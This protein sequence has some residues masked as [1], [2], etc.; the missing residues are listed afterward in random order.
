MFWANC[1]PL[2]DLGQPRAVGAF[3]LRAGADEAAAGEVEHAVLLGGQPQ[4]VARLPERLDPRE[5]VGVHPHLGAV[6]GE[7]GRERPHQLLPPRIAVGAGQRVE[8]AQHPAQRLVGPLQ[9]RNGVVVGG[10]RLLPGDG[11][12]VGARLG[13]RGL[14]RL[15]KVLVRDLCEGR[16]RVG[17]G[18]LGQQRVGHGSL[19][20]PESR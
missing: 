9:R 10:R 11:G 1:V 15:G 8:R 6:G 17:R 5:E 7:L 19:R 13:E 14:H 3:E 18:P 4:R 2:G 16:Q 12:H 20:S